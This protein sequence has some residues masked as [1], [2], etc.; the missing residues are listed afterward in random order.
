MDSLSESSR[1]QCIGFADVSLVSGMSIYTPH[2]NSVEL[3]CGQRPSINDVSVVYCA[4]AAFTGECLQGFKHSNIAGNHVSDG[5]YHKGFRCKANTGAFVYYNKKWQFLY[6]SYDREFRQAEQ[7]G[8]MAFAQNM[9]IF[10]SKVMPLFRKDRPLNIYRALCE[11]NGILCVVESHGLLTYSEY[12]EKLKGLGVKHALY[13]DMGDGW[14]YSW[15][16]DADGKLHVIH[17]QKPG[18]VFQTNWIV[19]R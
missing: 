5:V 19:F 17:P 11:L 14:N 16:R 8:G 7:Q 15:Y 6:D 10:N 4:E 12:V 1:K 13:L 18:S 9:I 3:A 2:F